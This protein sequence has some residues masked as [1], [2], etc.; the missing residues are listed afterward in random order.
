M[1]VFGLATGMHPLAHVHIGTLQWLCIIVLVLAVAI[2][3]A[4]PKGRDD[5]R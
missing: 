2:W 4:G 3:L 1:S 5:G